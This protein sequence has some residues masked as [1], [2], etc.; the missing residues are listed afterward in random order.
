M[1]KLMSLDTFMRCCRHPASKGAQAAKLVLVD[2]FTYK[3]A[4]AQFGINYRGVTTAVLKV[5]DE[6]D[7]QELRASLRR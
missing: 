5:Q 4:A 2:G 6:R 3:A 7:I 1:T